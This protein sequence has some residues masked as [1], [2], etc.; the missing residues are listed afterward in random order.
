MQSKILL[1][2]LKIWNTF[3]TIPSTVVLSTPSQ[4]IT[5]FPGNWTPD[6]LANYLTVQ[7]VGE[8]I[9]VSFDPYQLQFS[10]CPQITILDTSTALPYLGF[11]DNVT[12]TNVQ[13]SQFPPVKLKGPVCLNVYTNFTMDT[14]PF[15]TFLACVPVNVAYGEHIFFQ[16]YDDSQGVISLDSDIQY[17]RIS[18]RDDRGNLIDYPDEL[19]WEV[20]L[21]IQ[22]VLPEGFA[23]L[24][25]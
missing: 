22:S 16:Q 1:Q 4:N 18:L 20:I 14:I 9:T 15:S 3:K 19:D 25:I 6:A 8:G 17:I 5:I 7:L 10:F 2:S 13:I 23:P 24:E 11:P 12:Q 21:A